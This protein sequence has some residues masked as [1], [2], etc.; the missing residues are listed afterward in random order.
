MLTLKAAELLDLDAGKIVRPELLRIEADR[1]TGVGRPPEG[2]ILDL[3]ELILLPG[4]MDMDSPMRWYSFLLTASLFL[5][6]ASL[7][8]RPPWPAFR[9]P[10][11]REYDA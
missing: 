1:I 10:P 6:T 8:S 4:L 7:A 3:G 5:L 9:D 11:R 2:E